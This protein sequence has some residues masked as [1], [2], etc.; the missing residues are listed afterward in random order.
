MKRSLQ[1][2]LSGR[3]VNVL[4]AAFILVASLAIGLNGMV[5]SRLLSE[6]LLNAQTD[7]LS[8]DLDLAN[9]F[10]Q[11][12]LN[13]IVSISQF[14][15]LDAQTVSSLPSAL[16]GSSTST[17]KID[18]VINRMLTV[19]LLNG[20]RMVVVLD[21]KGHILDGR[22]MAADGS[23]SPAFIAG[24]WSDLP[25]VAD[26]LTSFTP[27]TGTEVIP[28]TFLAD[29]GLAK[30]AR[31]TPQDTPMSNPQLYN[32]LEGSA[33]LAIVGV[34][35]LLTES[36]QNRGVVFSAY[37]FNNDFSLVDYIKN[38]AKVE[39]MTLFLGD[40]RVSTNVT[41]ENNQR[42]VGT[43][44]S[45]D[46]YQKV[47][48]QGEN[49]SGRVFVVNNWYIGSYE[50]LKDYKDKVVGMMYVGVR[51]T[52]FDSLMVAFNT[53]SA[54]IA[55]IC[56]LV[57][58]IFAIPIA[59]LI[60]RPIAQLVEANRRLATGDMN[61]RVETK[62]EGEIA[63]LG[64]SFNNMVETLNES[65]KELLH[66]AKLASVG[67]LAAGVAHELNNPLGTILLY[68]DMMLKEAAEGDPRKDDLKMII[69]EVKRCKTIV[70]D[71]LNFARQHEIQ[72]QNVDLHALIDEVIQKT[73]I[74]P[75][76]EKIEFVRQYDPNM[77]F[78]EADGAQLHQVFSNLIS[79]SCY[80][81]KN[82]GR[83]TISTQPIGIQ[84]VEIKVSDTGSGIA[85]EHLSKLFTPF[86]TTKPAG[87]GTGLGLSIV[88][89]II[90]LHRGQITVQSQVGQGTT[91]SI[92]LPIRLPEGTTNQAV[93]SKELIG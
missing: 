60:T 54:W 40:M 17:A 46:V 21:E 26:A 48:L 58:A 8:R 13:D 55:G 1:W 32:A 11:Q 22:S 76:Y 88:Y 7:R 3:L 57:A 16:A 53:R 41:D 23:I 33:G 62:G 92:T 73:C 64:R 27:I 42:A 86:F 80:A 90:K 77:P 75:R 10:Y 89:G 70:A 6:Y 71:L 24:D 39:T 35:P 74:Q 29:A 63:L 56:I 84:Y 79:N 2:P 9:G 66:Q 45:Q 14:V 36:G 34:Y 20:T 72:A 87:K 51:E 81:M 25:I 82:V 78:I 18:Q 91:I 83:I 69:S 47:L 15:A 4:I 31:I 43:R 38:E 44:A 49:Y 93:A 28:A 37:L 68:S 65:E 67:Q 85:P 52:I 59:R 19:P 12:R 30:Q 5:N 50:P 61:V